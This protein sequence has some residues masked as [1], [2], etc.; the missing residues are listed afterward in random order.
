M[1]SHYRNHSLAA[2]VVAILVSTTALQSQP[3]SNA[4][5]RPNIP[6][7]WD[8]AEVA[9]MEIPLAA[10]APQVDAEAIFGGDDGFF[11]QTVFD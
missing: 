6:K 2:A 10:P 4:E 5:F 7:V 11:P 8:D 3:K 1:P 9:A